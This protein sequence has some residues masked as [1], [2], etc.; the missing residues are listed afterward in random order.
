MADEWWELAWAQFYWLLGV[1]LAALPFVAEIWWSASLEHKG[2]W[3]AAITA[4]YKDLAAY[5]MVIAA[6]G[7]ADTFEAAHMARNRNS[8]QQLFVMTM[9]MT[10]LLA[11][12]LL[13]ANF[14]MSRA[15]SHVLALPVTSF[16]YFMI[17]AFCAKAMAEMERR[18]RR[19]DHERI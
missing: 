1:T 14:M 2:S 5:V 16:A 8:L 3:A 6:I 11:F 9:F 17:L 10:F 15:G 19:R 7:V 18:T 4:H 12:A 13:F